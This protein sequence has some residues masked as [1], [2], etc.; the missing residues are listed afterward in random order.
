M[1]APEDRIRALVLAA[2]LVAAGIAAPV[3]WGLRDD[4]LTLRPLAGKTEQR[5]PLELLVNEG[6]D[7]HGLETHLDSTCKGGHRWGVDWS[8]R[9]PLARVTQRG[10][11]FT[12]REIQTVSDE[13]TI[14]RRVIARLVGRVDGET[15]EGTMRLIA[16]FYRDG[17]EMQAC[18]SGPFRW[19]AGPGAS[20]RLAAAG[21]VRRARGGYWLRVPSLAGRISAARRRFIRKTDQTCVATFAPTQVALRAFEHAAGDPERQRDAY[22]AYVEAHADQL[23]ALEGLGTPPDGVDR[24]RRWLDNFRARVQ[25]ERRALRLIASGEFARARA[26]RDRLVSL[27]VKGNVAGQRFGLQ[28]CTSNGPDRTPAPR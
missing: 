8:P 13:E 18:D 21:P 4:E 17:V 16:R 1:P 22:A 20:G 5:H 26:T 14:T 24:H 11:R 25:L 15:A 2:V 27:K 9:E 12:V 10:E 28:V 7:V 6:G 19:A 3:V 23:R